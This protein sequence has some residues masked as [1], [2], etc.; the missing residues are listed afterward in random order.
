LGK[1]AESKAYSLKFRFMQNKAS[2]L[3]EDDFEYDDEDDEI[4]QLIIEASTPR[5][6]R[7]PISVKK[8]TTLY[9]LFALSVIVA[10]AV[11][12]SKFSWWIVLAYPLIAGGIVGR[13]GSD[14]EW[15]LTARRKLEEDLAQQRDTFI[16]HPCY[17]IRTNTK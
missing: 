6:V 4:T 9:Y 16:N 14:L 7:L 1:I 15:N 13:I 3:M 5:Q 8:W 10:G 12:L 2:P 11:L 17:T